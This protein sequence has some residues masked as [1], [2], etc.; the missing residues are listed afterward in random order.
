MEEA[1]WLPEVSSGPEALSQLDYVVSRVDSFIN[2]RHLQ[3]NDKIEDGALL[4]LERPLVRRC[5]A[6]P[7]LLEPNFDLYVKY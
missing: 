5:A 1:C 4:R 7:G 2:S 3:W 6:R